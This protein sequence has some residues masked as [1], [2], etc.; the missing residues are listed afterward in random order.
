MIGSVTIPDGVLTSSPVAIDAVDDLIVDGTQAVSITASA[1]GYVDG[2]G[3]LQVADFEPLMVELTD[4]SI[5]EN[6]GQ[7][8]LVVTRTDTSGDLTV[9]LTSSDATAA[10]VPVSIVIPAG[11]AQSDPITVSAVDDS[12]LDGSQTT[13][14]T[15]SAV[16]YEPAGAMLTVTDYEQLVVSIADAS[17]SEHG[18]VT[19]ATISRGSETNGELTVQL[20]TSDPTEATVPLTVTIPDGQTTS[21]PFNITGV[22]DAVLDGTRTTTISASATGYV[23]GT[24]AIDVTD[25]EPLTVTLS[26]STISENGGLTTLTVSR[27][28]ASTALVVTLGS[29]DTSEINVPQIVLLGIGQKV[30]PPVQVSAVDDQLLDGTQTVQITAS[31]DLYASGSASIDV[32]DVEALLLTIQTGLVPEGSNAQ[33]TVTRTD[34]TGDLTVTLVS[35]D[36]SEATVPTT[37][38]IPDGQKVSAPF[39]IA[40]VDDGVIDGTNTVLITASA[41][42]YLDAIGSIDVRDSR[43]L[44]LT[45]NDLSISEQGGSTTATVA[46]LEAGTALT[47]Q[48][49]ADVAGAL[50]LPASVT[51]P[52]GAT[53]SAPFTISA[54]DDQLVN[55]D[56]PITITASAAGQ[57]ADSAS[58]NVTDFEPLSLSFNV[59]SVLEQNGAGTGTVTRTDTRGDLQ[60]TLVADQADELIVPSSI[61]IP[62]GQPSATFSIMGVND[63]VIDGTQTVQ[64]TATANGYESAA[65]SVDVVE[66]RLLTVIV[67]TGAISERNGTTSVVVTRTDSNGELVV[68][69]ESSD[70]SELTLPDSITIPDGSL[71]SASVLISAVDDTLLDGDQTVMITASADGHVAGSDSLV[72]TDY[73][74]LLFSPLDVNLVEG[75]K[76]T[77]TRTNSD[78]AQ[79]LS[80][81]VYQLCVDERA[82]YSRRS[83]SRQTR[84]S[85]WTPEVSAFFDNV[86]RASG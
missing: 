32:T 37:I 70:T 14:I 36:T 64:V 8:T 24:A 66:E 86:T 79:P 26:A 69:L 71:S 61:T 18:G 29:S 48:L 12:V 68:A 54:I 73:E 59:T 76:A 81:C 34:A 58:L 40:G 43:A 63:N 83:P 4:A 27:E 60:V 49:A 57:D 39:D 10:S 35:N 3:V 78:T 28:D 75:A 53:V 21:A 17:I 47:V 25:F 1:T 67:G 30:S 15:A 6:G 13:T 20:A 55:G 5:S 82:G 11:A 41:A 80:V 62:D 9:Q 23:T 44:T 72:V 45:I 38:V 52:T 2:V 42:G 74:Q 56:R 51:I 85:V 22:D 16:G 33:A 31:A 84:A 7:T 19:T 50:I 77:L 46:R 65:A